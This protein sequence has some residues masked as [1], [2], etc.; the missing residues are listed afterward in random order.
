MKRL[1]ILLVV[2]FLSLGQNFE[3][4][5]ST[6]T[7]LEN[8]TTICKGDSILLSASNGY[9]YLW[10]TGDTTA[11]VLLFPS[12]TSTFSV[13]ISSLGMNLDSID[14]DGICDTSE[15]PLGDVNFDQLINV[16]D[17]VLII[18]WILSGE[19]NACGDVNCDQILNEDD[20]ELIENFILGLGDIDGCV[21]CFDDVTI[22]VET[23]GCLD[24][25]AC[26]YCPSCTMEDE[27]CWY[28]DC[29]ETM[30][31]ENINPPV[32][33]KKLNALGI[34]TMNKGLQLY[35]YDNGAVEKKYLIK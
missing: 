11:S 12:E 1:L 8:D 2:P 28:D 5:C 33:Y 3:S 21:N 24:P 27:S 13:Q 35:I 26:N 19:Y 17:I 10:S 22:V 18:D 7:I 15:F 32:L 30:L 6:I 9:N 23:C 25:E 29:N 14:I 34:E 31:S 20:I 4:N 16:Q